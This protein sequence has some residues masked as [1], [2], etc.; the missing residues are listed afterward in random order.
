MPSSSSNPDSYENDLLVQRSEK[1]KEKKI[2]SCTM[3]YD[4]VIV[5]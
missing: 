4:K 5:Q 3:R 2:T 1:G